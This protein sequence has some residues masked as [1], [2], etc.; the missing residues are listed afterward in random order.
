[1]KHDEERFDRWDEDAEESALPHTS[2]DEPFAPAD[3]S[4]E[5]EGSGAS[6]PFGLYLRQ[7]GA[8]PMLS[9]SQELELTSRLDRLRRR[10]RRAAL[11]SALVLTRVAET[12]ERIQAGT[13]PLE[14]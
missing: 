3:S 13:L 2:E 10:Y 5:I 4:T 12:F 7:M 11:W 9:R 8:I 1:M 14:R 6:D